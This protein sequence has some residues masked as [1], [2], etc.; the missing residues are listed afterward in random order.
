VCVRSNIYTSFET[1]RLVFLAR[2]CD[3]IPCKCISVT[4]DVFAPSPPPSLGDI[5]SFL[6][7]C[8]WLHNLQV[9]TSVVKRDTSKLSRRD[10]LELVLSEAPELPALMGEVRAQLAALTES[11]Q[12]LVSN[13]TADLGASKDGLMYLRTR[14]QLL[15]AY[16]M[17]VCFYMILKVT[18]LLFFRAWRRLSPREQENRS[19]FPPRLVFLPCGSDGDGKG[20]GFRSPSPLCSLSL[21]A[22]GACARTIF[23]LTRA[24]SCISKLVG[25]RAVKVRCRQP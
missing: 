21:L 4:G 19:L 12:P 1:D 9:E 5:F 7:P 14:Q 6:T 8:P 16:C 13:V 24:G 15:L 10:K 20:F 17:N 2:R 23:S 22:L 11:V 18:L 25:L 3:A